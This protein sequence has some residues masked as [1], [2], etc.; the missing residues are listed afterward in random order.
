MCIERQMMLSCFVLYLHLRFFFASICI[1]SVHPPPHRT[2]PSRPPSSWS[3]H[4]RLTSIRLSL[5]PPPRGRTHFDPPHTPFV[6]SPSF[7]PSF[8][9]LLPT[10]MIRVSGASALTT[11]WTCR[12]KRDR[13]PENTKEQTSPRC[14][15]YD[16]KSGRVIVRVHLT[17]I[18]RR[19]YA[20]LAFK[21]AYRP[22]LGE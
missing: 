6:I 12:P 1:F 8:F 3:S 19:Y 5:R 17:A 4:P 13:E 21:N 15:R 16:R 11:R 9:H 7:L 22:L 2:T 10:L 20:V 18:Y 14:T